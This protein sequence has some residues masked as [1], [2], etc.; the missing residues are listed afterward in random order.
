MQSTSLEHS[1]L[2]GAIDGSHFL[3]VIRQGLQ[4]VPPRLS[5]HYRRHAWGVKIS[6]YKTQA[7]PTVYIYSRNASDSQVLLPLL[8]DIS[9]LVKLLRWLRYSGRIWTPALC[10]HTR[11]CVFFRI[12]W[13]GKSLLLVLKCAGSVPFNPSPHIFGHLSGSTRIHSGIYA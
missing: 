4:Y 3:L 13:N 11:T 12:G 10:D 5:T 2:Q 1:L 6:S 7:T 8:F 9:L